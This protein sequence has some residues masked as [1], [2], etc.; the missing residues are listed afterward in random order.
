M[1]QLRETPEPPELSL[2]GISGARVDLHYSGTVPVLA[3]CCARIALLKERESLS[4]ISWAVLSYIPP[5][6]WNA[7]LQF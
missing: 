5:C 3:H 1:S 2:G 4:P 6:V 7:S